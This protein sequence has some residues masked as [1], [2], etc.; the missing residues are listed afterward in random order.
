MQI[1]NSFWKSIQLLSNKILEITFLKSEMS[2]LILQMPTSSEPY[3][4]TSLTSSN[5]S[6]SQVNQHTS[7]H[8][9][10]VSTKI[11]ALKGFLILYPILRNLLSTSNPDA[12]ILSAKLSRLESGS[13]QALAHQAARKYMLDVFLC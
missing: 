11:Q 2:I 13:F 5:G 6:N 12:A 7:S 4:S 8:I 10:L 3:L 1:E 9:S